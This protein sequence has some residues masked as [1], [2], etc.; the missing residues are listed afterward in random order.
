MKNPE[1]FE[2]T[3]QIL[4]DA[5]LNKTL[6]AGNCSACAV[7]NMIAAACE[8]PLL[9]LTNGAVYWDEDKSGGQESTDWYYGI[10]SSIKHGTPIGE[11]LSSFT[12]SSGYRMIM[13]TGYTLQDIVDIETAFEAAIA[14]ATKK[15]SVEQQAEWDSKQYVD[16]RIGLDAVYMELL[17]I[18]EAEDYQLVRTVAFTL[19]EEVVA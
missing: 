15:L 16:Q 7:G 12:G 1:L 13:S 19:P 18:H 6:V 11:I 10:V 8:I 2:R 5:Y 4:T 3:V 14:E 9:K 17:R